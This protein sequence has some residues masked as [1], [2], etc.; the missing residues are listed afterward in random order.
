VASV[1]AVASVAAVAAWICGILLAVAESSAPWA[2]ASFAA[3]A[4]IAAVGPAYSRT[5][6]SL[7]GPAAVLSGALTAV[8]LTIT[9]T[10]A[11]HA[12]WDLAI[13]AACGS[14][15]TVGALAV[16]RRTGKSA[17][18]RLE[19]GAAGSAATL[20][21]AG[22]LAAPVALVG[23]FGWHRLLPVWAGYGPRTG[24]ATELSSLPGASSSAIALALVGLA[25]MLVRVARPGSVAPK[26]SLAAGVA[27]LIA[28]AL[29]VGSVPA[30]AHL[31]G[32]A[33]QI[34]LTGAVAAFLGVSTLLGDKVLADHAVAPIASPAPLP[35]R[36]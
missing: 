24:M 7:A 1:R 26:V 21:A 12:R 35:R 34:T 30:A 14:S 22:L 20:A 18:H 11:L 10:A 6:S 23:L 8:S 4:L 13:L 31:T 29:A 16:S 32:W 28:A 25:C 3:A 17:G 36:R 15:V 9:V 33:A 5:L 19:L 27:G 2:A